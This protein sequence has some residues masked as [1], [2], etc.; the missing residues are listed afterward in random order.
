MYHV[1]LTFNSLYDI[2][3]PLSKAVPSIKLLVGFS[4]LLLPSIKRGRLDAIIINEER[5]WAHLIPE[6][7]RCLAIRTF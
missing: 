5:G 3:L 4:T 2:L 6:V 1:L 7:L